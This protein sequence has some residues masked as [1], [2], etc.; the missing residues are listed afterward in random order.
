MATITNQ[1]MLGTQQCIR[2]KVI[3]MKEFSKPLDDYTIP[4]LKAFIKRF[5]GENH[6][7]SLWNWSKK[8]LI[9]YLENIIIL[10]SYPSTL[11]T[12][13][14]TTFNIKDI[15]PYAKIFRE[16]QCLNAFNQTN[17]IIH[18]SQYEQ[19]IVIIL[20]RFLLGKKWVCILYNSIILIQLYYII[21][22]ILY[23]QEI[24]H[25]IYLIYISLR[26]LYKIFIFY[27]VFNVFNIY[28][29]YLIYLTH[30]CVCKIP[31]VPPPLLF[32]NEMV[33]YEI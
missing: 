18:I 24:I 2:Y 28:I 10:L 30:V 17:H 6:Q 20:L 21:Y 29:S 15:L 1:V 13:R 32:L 31:L 27:I 9:I 5:D 11:Q 16:Y 25:L 7:H 12:D 19:Y 33:R 22:Y 4:E 3:T 14:V 8:E 23:C 26:N